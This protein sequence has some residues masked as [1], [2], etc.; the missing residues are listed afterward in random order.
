MQAGKEEPRITFQERWIEDEASARRNKEQLRGWGLYFG[1]ELPLKELNVI[2]GRQI[3]QFDMTPLFMYI[4]I[5]WLPNGK[6]MLQTT[7]G[8]A[9][10]TV[11]GLG[12]IF[13]I[14]Q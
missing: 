12:G 6:I 5:Q 14:N 8:I 13:H 1:N 10:G 9:A 7:C 3:I 4:H 2:R 11:I